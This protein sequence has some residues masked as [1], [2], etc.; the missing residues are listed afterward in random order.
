MQ[1][2]R[3][4]RITGNT[5]LHMNIA[6][7]TFAC[8]RCGPTPPR[9]CAS[10]RGR[11]RRC[12]RCCA[13]RRCD[14]S[15]RHR[16]VASA[17]HSAS[18]V[19]SIATHDPLTASCLDHRKRLF[20]G[21]QALV[22]QQDDCAFLRETDRR[23][24]PVT[25]R[26]AGCLPC[27]DDRSRSC[28]RVCR[29]C[30]ASSDV[31]VG[32]PGSGCT[33]KLLSA[34]DTRLYCPTANTMSIICCVLKCF[35]SALPRRVGDERIRMQLVCRLQQQTVELAPTVCAGTGLQ[36]PDLVVGEAGLA[37]DHDVLSPFVTGSAEV[38]DAQNDELAFARGQRRFAEHV[39]REHEPSAHAAPD[40]SASSPKMLSTGPPPKRFDQSPSAR[41][42]DRSARKRRYAWVAHAHDVLP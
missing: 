34:I 35:A 29:S 28:L 11:P 10:G 14:R 26:L 27:T 16:R 4:S 32:K 30:P 25:N 2:E 37:R 20:R 42:S 33:P 24:T 31:E 36:T 6:P 39:V 1:P 21:G 23:R 7:L 12:R 15:A 9:S 38:T 40:D 18:I 17:A 8:D 19:T 41:R 3:C 5:C 13:A 22:G